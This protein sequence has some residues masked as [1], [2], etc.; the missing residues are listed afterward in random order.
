MILDHQAVP[1]AIDNLM[2]GLEENDKEYTLEVLKG[3]G[4][5]RTHSHQASTASVGP[6]HLQ[7]QVELPAGA[8]GNV[9]DVTAGQVTGKPR[10]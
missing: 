4:A 7:I 3:R 6:M 5:F 10:E 9:I 1:L 2:K 8:G